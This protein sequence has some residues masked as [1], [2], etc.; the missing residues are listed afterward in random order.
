MF[1]KQTLLSASLVV[2]L[3][4]QP[5]VIAHADPATGTFE[6]GAGYSSIEGFIGRARIAQPSLFGTGHA[7]VLDAAVSGRRHRFVLDYTT[8]ELGGGLKLNAQLFRERRQMPGGWREGIGGALTLQQRIAPNLTAF[9]GMRVERVAYEDG[10]A[11]RTIEP[12][13]QQDGSITS[14]RGG[15]VYDTLDDPRAPL[16]GTQIGVMYDT[17]LRDLGSDWAFDR[18]RGWV[19]HHRGLG[20]LTL[21]LDASATQ[22]T[23][24]IPRS[25]R[26]YLDGTRDLRTFQFGELG[27]GTGLL[28][29]RVELEAP[30]IKRIGLSAVGFV[31]AGTMFDDGF[32]RT[33]R[34]AGIGLLWRSPIGPLRFDWSVPLDGGPARF[35]FGFG[36]AW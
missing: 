26:L 29:G 16:R 25:E 9:L 4:G 5:G 14:V 19:S 12:V 34:V 33:G 8:A 35:T 18:I 31:E 15:L 17:A 3:A 21:H 27:T 20:P 2:V 7:L 22:L 24:D 36:G 13:S 11:A 6:V 30:L 32:T 1:A 10:L 23:G 28:T